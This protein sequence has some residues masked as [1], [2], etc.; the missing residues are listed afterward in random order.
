MLL[1]YRT[2]ETKTLRW[3]IHV[4]LIIIRV[5]HDQLI[6]YQVRLGLIR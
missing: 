4:V 2:Y 5:K 3:H 1:R 6:V